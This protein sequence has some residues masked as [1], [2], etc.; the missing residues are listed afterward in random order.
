MSYLFD[1]ME[2][3]LATNNP[4]EIAVRVGLQTCGGVSG[5]LR[6]VDYI[7]DYQILKIGDSGVSFYLH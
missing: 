6:K 2:E 4:M 3:L 1:T 7:D 5:C